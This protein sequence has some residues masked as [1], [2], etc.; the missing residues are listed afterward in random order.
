MP[1]PNTYGF[2]RRDVARIKA[3][4]EERAR[5]P[6]YD[7]EIAI[8][9]L[10]APWRVGA[11][12]ERDVRRLNGARLGEWAGMVLLVWPRRPSRR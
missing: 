1:I 12:H 2:T 10:D 6:G 11:Y 5:A 3:F 7:I 8:P 4:A 9:D